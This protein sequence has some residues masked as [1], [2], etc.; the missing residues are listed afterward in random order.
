MRRLGLLVL[1]HRRLVLVLAIAFLPVAGILG[2]NVKQHLSAGGFAHPAPESTRAAH[3]LDPPFGGR[4]P[5]PVVLITPRGGNADD[6]A[7]QAAAP[8]LAARTAKAPGLRGGKSD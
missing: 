4:A 1:S 2:G 5:H 3:L 7:A 6:P 8:P